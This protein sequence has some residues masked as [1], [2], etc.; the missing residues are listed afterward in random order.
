MDP[1]EAEE[2]E[3][4]TEESENSN[5]ASDLTVPPQQKLQTA[6][7]VTVSDNDRERTDFYSQEI[8]FCP[9][10]QFLVN[11]NQFVVIVIVILPSCIDFVQKPDS[12]TSP[13]PLPRIDQQAKSPIKA[14]E[15]PKQEPPKQEDPKVEASK[16]VEAP[17]RPARPNSA[18]S[19]AVKVTEQT[20]KAEEPK[21]EPLNPE[22]KQEEAK[23][24]A[25][26]ETSEVKPL[27]PRGA[28]PLP[29]ARTDASSSVDGKVVPPKPTPKP[30]VKPKPAE[31][32]S[33]AVQVA[34]LTKLYRN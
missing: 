20:P 29:P 18:K 5:E 6:P 3:A 32:D 1:D 2:E 11:K 23:T 25:K 31:P 15:Q 26:T 28:L 17:K 30:L 34:K 33:L 16:L 10:N 12:P 19:D 14:E 24:E 8:D 13:R 4:T 22:V 7:V 27:S 21:V 9:K